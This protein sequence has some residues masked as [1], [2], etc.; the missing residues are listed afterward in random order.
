MKQH[1]SAVDVVFT[2]EDLACA[3]R[4]LKSNKAAGP[5]G[6]ISKHSLYAGDRLPVL[7]TK[8]F[9]NCLVYRFMP[10]S[11]ATSLI[12]PVPKSDASKLNVFEWFRSVLLINGISNVLEMSY[13]FT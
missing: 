10:E 4:S 3:I 1:E 7:L 8:L 9:N 2:V 12:E 11:F 5:D 6:R 13:E